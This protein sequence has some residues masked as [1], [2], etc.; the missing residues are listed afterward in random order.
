MFFSISGFLVIG[1]LL[2]MVTGHRQETLKVF[3]A[4]RWL[5][6]VPTYWILLVLFSGTGAVAWLGWSPLILNGLFSARTHGTGTCAAACF[7]E[8]GD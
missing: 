2:D 5:R 4:R 3:V 7:M 6:T 8:S 1:Q